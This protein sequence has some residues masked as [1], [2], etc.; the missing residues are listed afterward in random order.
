[1]PP[2]S[3][4]LS[5]IMSKK[6]NYVIGGLLLLRYISLTKRIDFDRVF[7]D[8]SSFVGHYM[9]I[10]VVQT[11]GNSIRVGLIVNKKMGNA[12]RRNRIRRLLKEI[13]RRQAHVLPKGCDVVMLPRGSFK[14][15]S[16]KYQDLSPEAE[17]L[18]K[19]AA[20]AFT[21]LDKEVDL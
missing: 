13:F 9:V 5:L 7:K 11:D 14:N 12:V 8:G 3:R 21:V 4:H 16:L 2:L 17:S 19:K 18:F 20:G 1:M 15:E 10:N 6:H